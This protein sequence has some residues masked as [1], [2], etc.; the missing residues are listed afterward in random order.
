MHPK[1]EE[2]HALIDGKTVARIIIEF[3]NEFRDVYGTHLLA[4]ELTAVGPLQSLIGMAI[5][6]GHLRASK[7]P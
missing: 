2:T 1:L 6:N 5:K 3:Q 4:C 7:E